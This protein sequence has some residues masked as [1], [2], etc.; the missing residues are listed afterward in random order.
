MNLRR[1][2]L[3]TLSAL[4]TLV[5]SAC[6]SGGSG[7]FNNPPPPGTYAGGLYYNYANA[8]RLVIRAGGSFWILLGEGTLSSFYQ[9]GFVQGANIYTTD[10]ANAILYDSGYVGT[11]VNMNTGQDGPYTTIS[12]NI[13]LTSTGANSTFDGRNYSLTGFSP[14][15]LWSLRDAAGRTVPVA[16]SGSTFSSTS[17]CFFNGTLN[18]TTLPGFYDVTLNDSL[19][20]LGLAFSNYAGIAL[21]ETPPSGFGQQIMMAVIGNARGISLSGVRP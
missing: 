11:A 19:G 10:Y 21:T 16:V 15:G 8:H 14:D 2:A 1:S 6:G 18:G 4:S 5:L 17:G 3:I 13:Q 12:G 20:C 7:T 9:T